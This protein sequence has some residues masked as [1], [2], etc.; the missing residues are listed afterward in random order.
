MPYL[1]NRKSSSNTTTPTYK[2]PLI[3]CGNPD[4]ELVSVPM[5]A[6][7]FGAAKENKDGSHTIKLL[8]GPHHDLEVRVYTPYPR[9]VFRNELRTDVYRLR[10]PRLKNGPWMFV[11]D[12]DDHEPYTPAEA[13]GDG[14]WGPS[15]TVAQ[16]AASW[17]NHLRYKRSDDR[18]VE[19]LVAARQPTFAEFELDETGADDDG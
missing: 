6:V 3:D 14:P 15:R 17:V 8:G 2:G 16:V 12:E 13:H 4:D 9:V 10:P 19:Q 1:N 5:A 7:Q 18:K 11:H